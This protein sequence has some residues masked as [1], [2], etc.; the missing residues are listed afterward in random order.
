MPFVRQENALEPVLPSG[1]NAND[2]VDAFSRWHSLQ[3]QSVAIR[4]LASPTFCARVS[5][6]GTAT[7]DSIK[8]S[9]VAERK[10]KEPA[11]K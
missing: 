11:A 10:G 6:T 2:V 3:D 9:A 5:V 1:L 7:G 4:K 8:V